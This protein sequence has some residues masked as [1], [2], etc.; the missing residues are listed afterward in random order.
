[1][2]EAPLP[3]RVMELD[4]SDNDLNYGVAATHTRPQDAPRPAIAEPRSGSYPII[5]MKLH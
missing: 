3:S 5:K 1:M 2:I 4:D